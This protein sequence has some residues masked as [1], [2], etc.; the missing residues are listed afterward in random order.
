M[1]VTKGRPVVAMAAGRVIASRVGAGYGNLVAVSHGK[2]T[3]GPYKGLYVSTLSAHHTENL[4][5][6]GEQVV[7]GQVIAYSGNTG[8]TAKRPVGFHTHHEIRVSE[9][10]PM[11]YDDFRAGDV[12]GPKDFAGM[13]IDKMHW[14]PEGVAPRA[15]MWDR[16][17]G[18]VKN[19]S[20]LEL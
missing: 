9:N 14:T 15:P 2:A 12:V 6:H 3:A 13:G 17:K 1:L 18:Y 10:E 5:E 8:G 16:I 4:I 7:E 11:N 19:A 20:S